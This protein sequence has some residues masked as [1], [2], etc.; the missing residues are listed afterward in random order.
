MTTIKKNDP[1]ILK[2]FFIIAIAGFVF[3]YFWQN[4]FYKTYAAEK[5]AFKTQEVISHG[6]T[7]YV[8]AAELKT[9]NLV[10]W[11]TIPVFCISIFSILIYK[12]K[13]QPSYFSINKKRE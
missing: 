13:T 8:N 12:Y 3:N 9:A 2:L 1:L 7:Y 11:I 4:N 10:K 6:I 5:T